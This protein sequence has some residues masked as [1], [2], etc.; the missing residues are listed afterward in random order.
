[1]GKIERLQQAIQLRTE[2][3]HA[4]S[5]WVIG[6]TVGGTGSD[7]LDVHHGKILFDQRHPEIFP[8]DTRATGMPDAER[9]VPRDMVSLFDTIDRNDM[10]PG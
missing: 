6:Q 8:V 3:F 1:M 2:A 7:R 4:V 10:N 9:T 5:S